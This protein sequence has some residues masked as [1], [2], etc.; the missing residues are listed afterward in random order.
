MAA[1][2]G[3]P[4]EKRLVELLHELGLL[5]RVRRSG[6]WVAGIKDPESVADHCFRTVAVAWLLA[7]LE[8]ADVE[9]ATGMALF[10]DMTETRTND[11]HR[12]SKAHVD[13][14][15]V[16]RK[17]LGDQLSGL[18]G[19][20]ASRIRSLLEEYGE[21][22]SLEAKVARDADRLECLLQA[23]EYGSLGVA[24]T[25]EWIE[26]NRAALVTESA[27]RLARECIRSDPDS[28]WHR[29]GESKDA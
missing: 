10:H 7:T 6:W 4:V 27:K 28:W 1:G 14:R 22:A 19:E 11:P 26:S 17:V 18:P 15:A 9:K 23:R 16:E 20:V 24:T 5:K 21:G 25:R 29:P 13:W 2:G 8:G 12:L 3:T